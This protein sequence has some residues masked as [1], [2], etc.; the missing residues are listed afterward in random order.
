MQPRDLSAHVPY[1][2]GR[3]VEEV[4]RGLGL[5]PENLVKLSSNENPFGPA[6]SAVEAVREHA[7]AA[8]RYPKSAAT[9]LR[10]RLADEWAVTR[11]QI[12][13]ANGGDGAL[14]CL[15]RA[16]LRPGESVLVPAPGFA[17]YAMSARYHHGVVEEYPVRKETGFAQTP[18]TVLP[19]Y[20]GQRVVYLTSPHNPAGS[21]VSAPDVE[22]VAERT[23]EETLV[24]VDEAYGEFSERPSATAL[25]EER[26]DVAVLRTFSK[27][28]GLAGDRKSVV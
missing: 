16:L 7:P 1:E 13:L 15:A 19:H 24:L 22:A 21:E 26:D 9:D 18:E 14:D 6:P 10:E 2:A 17:Y 5:D 8:H 11:S 28:Y 4:A 27:A 20:D 12:C 23:G 3:G 25:V